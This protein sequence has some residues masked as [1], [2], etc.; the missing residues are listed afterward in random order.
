MFKETEKSC[1]EF[2]QTLTNIGNNIYSV[3]GQASRNKSE[4]A[5]YNNG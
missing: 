1:F 4:Q 3:D 2:I 5:S